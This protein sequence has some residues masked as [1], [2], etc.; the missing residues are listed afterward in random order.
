[1]KAA[2]NAAMEK[3]AAEKAL[4]EKQRLAEEANKMKAAKNAAMEK[5]NAETVRRRR[6][7]QKEA[8]ANKMEEARVDAY[9]D[10]RF[11]FVTSSCL[12]FSCLV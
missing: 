9:C 2:K 8:E 4:V 11:G 10:A 5:V 1:M 6:Q 3:E 12:V 7:R